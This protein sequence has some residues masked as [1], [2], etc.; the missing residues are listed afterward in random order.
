[1]NITLFGTSA[2]FLLLTSEVIQSVTGD[3]IH[4]SFCDWIPIVAIVLLPLMWLGSPQ[5]F[6]PAAYAA[7]GATIVGSILLMINIIKEA[8][9]Y[10]PDATYSGPSF[11][12][13]FLSFGKKIVWL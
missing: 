2:V 11:K 4:F 9:D 8:P 10:F 7:M 3:F 6:W 13:F 12:S 5:D 1:M